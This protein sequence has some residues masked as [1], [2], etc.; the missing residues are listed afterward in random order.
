MDRETRAEIICNLAGKDPNN[1]ADWAEALKEAD[2]Q[3]ADGFE[4]Q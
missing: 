3:I 1:E 2:Q 4:Y